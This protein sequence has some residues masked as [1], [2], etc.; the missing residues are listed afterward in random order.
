MTHIPVLKKEVLF[1]LNPKTNEN[2]V[3]C[4]FGEGGHSFAILEKN[5]PE[6]KILGIDRSPEMIKRVGKKEERIVLRQGKFSNLKE[7]VKEAN[8]GP[9]NGVLFDFGMSSWHIDESKKGFSFKDNEPLD[10]RYDSE[11]DMTADEIL[12]KMSY[13]KIKSIL[14]DYGEE[15]FA[16]RIASGIVEERKINLIETTVG[17]VNIIRKSTPGWYHHQRI[18]FATRTF[19][20]LRIAVNEELEEIKKG[21]ESSMDI[22]EKGGRIVAI[23]F[24]SLED[25]IVK[26]FFRDNFK[27]GNL[28][29]LTKKP[30]IANFE[31]IKVNHRSRSAKLR[32]AI[33]N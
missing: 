7:I 12:N 11:E 9:V 3:D 32:A 13:E 29:I 21:L 4:T 24:H 26:N 20:A 19:Q 5:I 10:M 1:Y 17:L 25:R 33:I 23:S 28:K 22:L 15:R 31:E 30:V 14:K 27:K 16:G 8:F 6:G 2:F 18:H